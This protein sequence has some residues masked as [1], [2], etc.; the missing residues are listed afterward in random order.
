MS[1][2]IDPLKACLHLRSKE[3][4]YDFPDPEAD[5][6]EK[7]DEQFHESCDT[8]SFWCSC[9]QTGRGP[10]DQPVGREECCRLSRKCFVGIQSLA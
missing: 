10:D 1:K 4:F 8:T 2:R 5:E 9:T 6:Q 7:D 3:M